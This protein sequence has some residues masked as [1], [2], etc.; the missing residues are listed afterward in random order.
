MLKGIS[1]LLNPELLSTL[2]RMEQGDEIVLANATFPGESFN[3]N[4]IRADGVE[5]HHLLEAIL[6]LIELDQY[7]GSP[8]IMMDT[9]TGDKIDPNIELRYRRSIQITNPDI[10][11]I[12]KIERFSFFERT[13]KAYAVVITGETEKY[14]NIIIKKGMTPI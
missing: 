4:V 14:G 6:P 12:G 9:N 10:K 8:L 7:T 1:P 5:I 2:Y 3:K 11:E 13:T